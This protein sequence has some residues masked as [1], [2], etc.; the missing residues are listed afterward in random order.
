MAR[1]KE[2]KMHRIPLV[3]QISLLSLGTRFRTASVWKS[4]SKGIALAIGAVVVGGIGVS[5]HADLGLRLD[6]TN[7]SYGLILSHGAQQNFVASTGNPIQVTVEDGSANMSFGSVTA[8]ADSLLFNSVS[9]NYV[10]SASSEATHASFGMEPVGGSPARR[11]V[12]R[13]TIVGTSG[14]AVGTP[15]TIHINSQ[16]DGD[17]S[18]TQ[19]LDGFGIGTTISQNFTYK[20]GDVI[21]YYT[22]LNAAPDT[23]GNFSGT[24]S[25]RPYVGSGAAAPEPG[26][27]TLLGLGGLSL[28]GLLQRRRRIVPG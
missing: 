15:V 27:L 11:E 7:A 2:K 20:V 17:A 16:Y 1:L 3:N 5:A 8:T 21:E 24:L 14:E 26:S 23:G 4:A 9:F 12:W 25:I 19:F 13:M 22:G 28:I 18:A 10:I 6:R